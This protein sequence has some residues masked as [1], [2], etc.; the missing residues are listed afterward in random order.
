MKWDSFESHILASQR[1][2]YCTKQFSDVTLVSDDL[3][4]FLAHKTVLAS[5][6]P[7]LKTLLAMSPHQQSAFLYLKGIKHQDL[8]SILQYIYL[9]ETEISE[10]EVQEFTEIAKDL[11]IMRDSG[12]SFHQQLKVEKM[13]FLSTKAFIPSDNSQEDTRLRTNLG[14]LNEVSINSNSFYQETTNSE[15]DSAKTIENI[16]LRTNVGFDSKSNHFEK[17]EP[18]KSYSEDECD[19]IPIESEDTLGN[20]EYNDE[21]SEELQKEN[22]ESSTNDN[23]EDMESADKKGKRKRK[24]STKPRAKEDPADCD[25]CNIHYT[26]KRSYKR[27]Y[28]SVHELKFYDC[29]ECSEC[30]ETF[31]YHD[32]LAQHK[33]RVHCNIEWPC[34]K[35]EK[36]YKSKSDL[37]SHVLAKHSIS[38]DFHKMRFKTDE[39]LSMHIQE[40]HVKKYCT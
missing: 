29:D 21:I 11:G 19:E 8:E 39:E 22:E 28:M 2:L 34:K 36:I 7:K 14:F 20:E 37:R 6:S 3:V 13:E 33:N 12:Y 17:I 23:K 27:H 5:A 24:Q 18:L 9:G 32:T 35:C 4:E 26:T 15:Q 30:S 16:K 10:L 1:E 31:R 40:E 25:I 38:C